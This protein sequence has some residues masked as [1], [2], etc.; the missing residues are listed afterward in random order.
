MKVRQSGHTYMNANTHSFV[1]GLS[2][3]RRLLLCQAEP[4]REAAATV[5]AGGPALYLQEPLVI[6]V[7]NIQFMI[8]AARF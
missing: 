6:V 4:A 1:C 8:A 3:D 5:W 7:T 2:G